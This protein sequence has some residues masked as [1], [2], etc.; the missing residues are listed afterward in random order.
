[1]RTISQRLLIVP[2]IFTLLLGFG[3]GGAEAEAAPAALTAGQLEQIVDPI[4][5]DGLDNRHVPG[6]AVVVTQGERIIWSKGYGY[7]N[8][9][10]KIPVDPARTVMRVGSLTKTFTAVAAMQL[11]EQ[12][13]LTLHDDVNQFLRT[14]KIPVFKDQP[15]TLHHLLTYTSGLDE[16]IYRISASS[17]EKAL[18]ADQFLREY[19]SWKTP[20]REP[21]QE[22]EYSNAGIGLV[23]NIIEQV[24]GSDLG[25]YMSKNLFAP[26]NMPS[27]SLT[28]P[29]SGP[30]VAKSYMYSGGAYQAVPFSYVNLPGAGGLSVIPNEFAHFMIAMLNRGDF[31]GTAILAPSSVDEMQR[32]QFAESPDVAGMGYGLFRGKLADGSLTLRHTGDIE[33]FSAKMEL[34][35]SQELGILI[36]S[37]GAAEGMNINDKITDAITGL[38]T[39]D[40]PDVKPLALSLEQ[41]REYEHTYLFAAAPQQG[42]GKWLYFLGGKEFKVTAADGGLTLSGVFPDG[43]GEKREKFFV[44]V[45]EDLFQEKG[46][47]QQL[48]FDR[49]RDLR[50]TFVQETTMAETPEFWQRPSTL[51]AL[52]LGCGLLI[53][54]LSLIW[55][56]RYVLRLFRKSNKPVSL[57]MGI[58]TLSLSVF[59][60]IQLNY[61]N[62][63]ITFGYPAWFVWGVSSLPFLAVI[64][65]VHLIWRDGVKGFREKGAPLARCAVAAGSI[66]YTA[67]LFY[68]NMLSIHFS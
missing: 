38:F 48:W 24:S 13:K 57:H 18:S 31:Q 4:M 5:Q 21:G 68:W 41:L 55:L 62:S 3:G 16:I 43:T 40:T 53:I 7:A 54:V 45:A 64:A 51:I 36:V 2:V 44:P 1:M 67:F 52:Y 63:A 50:M 61:G 66:A 33:A 32:R 6:T 34:I 19:V 22:Y 8:V 11:A 20:V 14:Y 10:R 39:G 35:P 12:G 23:G 28:V 29:E 17:R 15:I 27:A 42:W 47:T 59:L 37:N 25:D 30:D 65:A 46:G 26:L 56:I 60:I 49:Q 58:I 9:E